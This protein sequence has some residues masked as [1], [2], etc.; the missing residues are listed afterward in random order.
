MSPSTH[1]LAYVREAALFAGHGN[2]HADIVRAALSRPE[3]VH[4][5][6]VELKRNLCKSWTQSRIV[7]YVNVGLMLIARH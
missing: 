3:K 4:C 6:L 7:R 1:I 5:E 2:K